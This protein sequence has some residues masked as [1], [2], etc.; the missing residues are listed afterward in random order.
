MNLA[1]QAWTFRKP[2]NFSLDAALSTLQDLNISQLEIAGTSHLTPQS[3][4]K[5]CDEFNISVISIHQPSPSKSNITN[6][7]N[8]AKFFCDLFGSKSIVVPMNSVELSHTTKSQHPAVYAQFAERCL[9]VSRQL[10]KQDIRLG[11]HVY[12]F[13]LM[14]LVSGSTGL[15]ILS[16][17]TKPDELFFQFDTFWAAKAQTDFRKLVARYPNRLRLPHIN[18]VSK[19][20]KQCAVGRG[21][22]DWALVRSVVPPDDVWV[23]EHDTEDP[24]EWVAHSVTHLRRHF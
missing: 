13:D 9:E 23:I 24:I 16:K 8:E 10:S 20:G 2:L 6:L 17:A 4:K 3:F 22:V 12:S 1:V 7:V 14:P 18:D 19:E 5:K 15:D 21:T 11:F